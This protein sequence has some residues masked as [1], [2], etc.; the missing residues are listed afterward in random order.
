MWIIAIALLLWLFL[1]VILVGIVSQALALT[2]LWT[3]FVVPSF[4]AEP[5]SLSVAAG[6][7]T[8]TYLVFSPKR[9]LSSLRVRSRGTDR[10]DE[11]DETSLRDTMQRAGYV[12]LGEVTLPVFA[13]A[14][15]WIFKQAVGS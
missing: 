2:L 12:L 6:L 15:G 10:K 1:A 11:K 13:V 7:I 5:L 8:I 14:L 9:D 3:W 4:G